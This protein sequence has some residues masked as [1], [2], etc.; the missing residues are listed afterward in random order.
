MKSICKVILPG[1]VAAA[2]CAAP[3]C[4]QIDGDVPAAG[5]SLSLRISDGSSVTTKSALSESYFDDEKA[6]K[7]VQVFIFN[8]TSDALNGTLYRKVDATA[9]LDGQIHLDNVNVGSYNIAVYLNGKTS[10]LDPIVALDTVKTLGSLRNLVVSLASSVPGAQFTMYGEEGGVYV[11]NGREAQATVNVKRFVSRI[12]LESVKL[13]DKFPEAYG[14]FVVDQAFVIN[15]YSSWRFAGSDVDQT[16]VPGDMVNVAGRKSGKAA[17]A[18]ADDFIAAASDVEAYGKFSKQTFLSYG[19]GKA[20]AKG[21][22][23]TF[24]DVFY[25]FPNAA[26][27]DEAAEGDAAASFSGPFAGTDLSVL[28]ARLVV[29]GHFSGDP[30]KKFYYP[31]TIGGMQRNHRYAVQLT[32]AGFG[33]DDPNKQVMKGS[34][35]V[36]VS[37]LDWEE[38]HDIPKEI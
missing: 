27:S 6:K 20:V 15:G 13:S 14:S 23:V 21:D 33:S 28:P 11:A 9:G 18:S 16:V 32:V 35:D 31:V 30:S 24:G 5:G 4:N 25:I 36:T 29:Y 10:A 1:L 34:L 26:A 3:A 38:N 37:V 12:M 7:D 8:S 19:E 22:A 2:L 17:S